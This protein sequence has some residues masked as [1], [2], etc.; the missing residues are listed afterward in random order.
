MNEEIDASVAAP[1]HMPRPLATAAIVHS[2]RDAVDEVLADFAL[3]LRTRGWKVCGVIQRQC[4]GEGKE[5]TLLTDLDGGASFPLFQRLGSGSIS[6]S[7]DASGVAAASVALR[8]ALHD[9]ADLAIANRFGALEAGGSGFAA[10]MLAL[11]SENRPLLTVVNDD[12]L[13]DW[14]WFTGGAAAELPPSL[15]ALEAWFAVIA[16]NLRRQ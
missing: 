14:R 9:G 10:E 1:R 12:Y 3:S 8:R 6:C 13:L 15:P 11:M 4:G 5:H 2:H 7:L 16:G